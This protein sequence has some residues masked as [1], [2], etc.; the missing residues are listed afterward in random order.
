MSKLHPRNIHRQPYD[1]V[2]LCKAHPA[3]QSFVLE[4]P[5]QLTINFSDPLAVKALNKAL[6]VHHY[7]VK[8]WDIPEGYLCPA[9]PGRADYIHYLADLLS[10]GNEKMI[11][12]GIN[13]KILDIGTG[14]N[15]IYPILGNRIYGWSFVG[16]EIDHKAVSTARAI[17]NFNKLLT[18]YIE[19]RLHRNKNVIFKGTFSLTER[20][21]ACICNPPFHASQAAASAATRRKHINLKG[22][23]S[24]SDLL[25][26]GGQSSELIYPKGEVGFI[27][28]MIYD[29]AEM[30]ELCTW[31]TTLVSQ[32]KNLP[33]LQKTLKAVQVKETRVIK[34][35]QGQKRSR[36]LAWRF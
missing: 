28:Q 12:K 14:A 27:Q 35:A 1:F 25:N 29:S 6:L 9:I 11:P 19:I 17:V 16:T 34:M 32:E 24:N 33:V 8:F 22:K 21:T 10:D 23:S 20:F 26:F 4:G 31:F 5:K 36:I 30:P 3:L 7:K 2:A 15:C 18:K 13:V